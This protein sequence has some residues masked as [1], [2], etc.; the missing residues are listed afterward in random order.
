MPNRARPLTIKYTPGQEY[1]DYTGRV[2]RVDKA[3]DI[4]PTELVVYRPQKAPE[5]AFGPPGAT[6]PPPPQ[7]LLQRASAWVADYVPGG[8]WLVAGVG[9]VV[10]WNLLVERK[11]PAPTKPK[12]LP[13]KLKSP[14]IKLKSLTPAR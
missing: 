4:Q 3:G 7:D 10:A 14:P 1:L 12:S 5:S 8:W 11:P 13:T 6:P 2:W 9:G